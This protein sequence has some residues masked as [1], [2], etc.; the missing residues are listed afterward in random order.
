MS[1]PILL[2]F[3]KVLFHLIQLLFHHQFAFL[4]QLLFIK[5]V[6]M[7]ICMLFAALPYSQTMATDM[8]LSDTQI[9]LLSL[10]HDV[11]STVLVAH[12]YCCVILL[13]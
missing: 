11:A 1:S 3:E 8:A 10:F 4:D 6:A 5:L 12:T 7:L 2:F 13:E 9:L